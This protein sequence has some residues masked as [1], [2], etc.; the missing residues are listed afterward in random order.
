[1]GGRLR[2]FTP[3]E[4]RQIQAGAH[5]GGRAGEGCLSPLGRPVAETARRHA[6]NSSIASLYR[7]AAS[8]ALASSAAYKLPACPAATAA[9]RAGLALFLLDIEGQRWGRANVGSVVRPFAVGTDD[10]CYTG[11]P[12]MAA[13]ARFARCRAGAARMLR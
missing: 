2:T 11:A 9:V 10:E 5:T 6:L 12:P 3:A 8:A 7:A 13:A 1:L 4:R